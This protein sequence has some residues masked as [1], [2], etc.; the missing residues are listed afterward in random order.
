MRRLLMILAFALLI[1]GCG[2]RSTDH[3]LQRLKDPDVVRRR[4]AI[5]ELGERP[6]DASRVVPALTEA[7]RDDNEFVRHDAATTLAKFG[8]DAEP[9][10][11]GLQAALKD[12]DRN[13]RRAAETTLKKVAPSATGKA[14]GR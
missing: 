3:W 6:A 8:P 13:V 11:P 9:A 10:V 4:E 2:P 5:R 12:R 14:G 1:A 7:L